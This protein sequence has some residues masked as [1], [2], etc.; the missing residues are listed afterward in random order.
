M[1]SKLL[2]GLSPKKNIK[3]KLQ[4]NC[5]FLKRCSAVKQHKQHML[6]SS[7]VLLAQHFCLDIYQKISMPAD[8]VFS[9]GCWKV[10]SGD[11]T[12]RVD[13]KIILKYQ[14]RMTL[15]LEPSTLSS[16]ELMSIFILPTS[17]TLSWFSWT[18][19]LSIRQLSLKHSISNNLQ[20]T[21]RW[22][23]PH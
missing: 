22:F 19:S 21:T 23:L 14:V 12:S 9:E 5:T 4:V 10:S 16:H 6:T 17:L 18:V 13:F 8:Q 1:P 11:T 7:V 20:I 3:I 2:K 15:A